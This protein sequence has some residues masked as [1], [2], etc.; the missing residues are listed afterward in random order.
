MQRKKKTKGGNLIPILRL[1]RGQLDLTIFFRETVV[2][3]GE[4]LGHHILIG[5]VRVDH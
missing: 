3:R 4:H 2:Y 5:K 1:M